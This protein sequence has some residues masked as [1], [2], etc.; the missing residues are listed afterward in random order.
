MGTGGETQIETRRRRPQKRP[1][2]EPYGG[3]G[4]ETPMG[5][6]GDP[7]GDEEET[8]MGTRRR[9][10]QKRKGGGEPYGDGGETPMGAGGDP[11]RDQEE[12]T[13]NETQIETRRRRARWGGDPK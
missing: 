11:K 4:E 7:D 2:G 8:P 9:R 3:T 12:E 6:G 1:G 5:A 13:P 10:P